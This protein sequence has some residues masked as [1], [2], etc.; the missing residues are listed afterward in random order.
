M[1]SQD[2]RQA[3]IQIAERNNRPH[4]TACVVRD[5][6]FAFHN[7]LDHP[8]KRAVMNE[9]VVTVD[10]DGTSQL[11]QLKKFCLLYGMREI[12][13]QVAG[14]PL[15]TLRAYLAC[16][17]AIT[18]KTWVKLQSSFDAALSEYERKNKKSTTIENLTKK[19]CG[20]AT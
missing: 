12:L 8:L 19:Y 14:V 7:D 18:D 17:R 6:L 1:K 13:A 4:Y 3:L 15:R 11:A 20:G 5:V 16:E 10:I 9:V 2:I